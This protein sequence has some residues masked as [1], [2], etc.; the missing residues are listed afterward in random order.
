[1]HSDYLLLCNK[2]FQIE[3]VKTITIVYFVQESPIWADFPGDGYVLFH[4]VSAKTARQS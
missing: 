2:P 1:M 3:Q 4:V